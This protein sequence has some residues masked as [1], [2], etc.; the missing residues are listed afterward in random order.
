MIIAVVFVVMAVIGFIRNERVCIKREKEFEKFT[1]EFKKAHPNLQFVEM[2]QI[3]VTKKLCLRDC[4]INGLQ[5]ARGLYY[6][7]DWNPIIQ[8]FIVYNVWGYTKLTDYEYK[9]IFA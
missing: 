8:S 3:M 5:F 7:I 6:D 2:P 1:E 9:T 4:T